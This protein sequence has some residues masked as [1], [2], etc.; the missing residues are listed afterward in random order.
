MLTDSEQL[1]TLNDA[2]IRTEFNDYLALNLQEDSIIEYQ[3]ELLCDFIEKY[4]LYCKDMNLPLLEVIQLLSIKLHLMPVQKLLCTYLAFINFYD[5]DNVRDIKKAWCNPFKYDMDFNVELDNTYNVLLA[6][7]INKYGMQD[8]ILAY[9]RATYLKPAYLHLIYHSNVDDY[10][11]NDAIVLMEVLNR[12]YGAEENEKMHKW[13]CDTLSKFNE[14][15]IV[16]ILN[17]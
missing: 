15:E 12:D 13:I 17:R 5:E 3:A 4:Y 2:Q 16:N 10:F 7:E 1:L 14:T 11:T 6:N 8:V 9:N